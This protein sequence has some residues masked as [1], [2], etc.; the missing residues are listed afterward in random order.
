MSPSFLDVVSPPSGTN[1]TRWPN[2]GVVGIVPIVSYTPRRDTRDITPGVSIVQ[3]SP[4]PPP[5]AP[6]GDGKIINRIHVAVARDQSVMR[7]DGN[8]SYAGLLCAGIGS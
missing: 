3:P 4:S 7:L 8:G 5:S 6:S 2:H 1:R